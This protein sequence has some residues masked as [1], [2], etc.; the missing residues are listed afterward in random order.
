MTRSIG[1]GTWGRALGRALGSAARSTLRHGKTA[2]DKTLKTV[3]KARQPPPGPGQW[4]SGFA[5]GS[6]GI[7]RF[8]LYKPP[9]LKPLD[10]V[11]LLVMLHGCS[12]DASTFAKSTRMNRVAERERFMVLYPEQDRSANAQGCWNWF[13]TKTGQ[14]YTEAGL[15]VAAIDQVCLLYPAD[16]ARVGIVGL[17][18][19]ASMGALV[20]TRYPDRFKAIVMHSGVQPGPNSTLSALG[21]AMGLRS[22][23]P[24]C[25]T[26]PAGKTS[27]ALPPL[28]VIHG[29]ADRVVAFNNARA[30]TDLWAQAAGAHAS[31]SRRVQRGQR[32]SSTWTDYRLR[33]KTVATLCEVDQLGHAWSGGDAAQP[34]SDANGPDASRMAWTFVAKQLG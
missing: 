28:L 25:P 9:G 4:T 32:Y 3:R 7:R 13:S 8:K 17:S 26:R 31:A 15:I 6:G 30:A 27:L 18:A 12:Q 2:L 34:F 22:A 21:A 33:R 19:G 29:T 20:V 11:P 23:A 10:R 5:M 14:A 16:R 1:N 24:A